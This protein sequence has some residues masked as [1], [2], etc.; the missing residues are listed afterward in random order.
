MDFG[1]LGNL[2]Q[3]YLGGAAPASSQ[4]YDDFDRVSQ[5]APPD[6][7]ADG[8]TEA[9]RS[10]QTPPFAQML[11]NLFG[12]TQGQERSSILNQLISTVGPA[13]V[14]S[15]I[16]SLSGLLGG[17]AR[18][19]TPD[20]AD[21]ISPDE[22]QQLAQEAEKKD[23]SIMDRIGGIFAE[24]PQLVKTLGSV[25]LTIAMAKIAKRQFSS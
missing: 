12:N 2:L 21:R 24:Q 23:P 1:A 18:E 7:I 25:A 10:D 6:A 15:R 3:N 8:V 14:A 4:V 13:L 11:A 9:F 19:I 20:Q 17:G 5:T 16:P 22:V